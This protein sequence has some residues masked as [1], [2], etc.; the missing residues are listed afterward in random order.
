MAV[1][2]RSATYDATLVYFDEPQVI[3]LISQ[4]TRIVAIA[5]P[6]G[7]PNASMFLAT[8]VADKDWNKY[9]D[10][11]VDLRYL[12][13]YPTVRVQYHFDLQTMKDKK[14]MMTPW[15]GEIAEKY[16]P[17]A[18]FFSTNHTED[19]KADD[20][21]K[22]IEKLLIDGEW[23]LQDFGQFQ[24]KYADVYAFI[25]ATDT[26]KS[27]AASVAAKRKVK[28]AFLDR[29]FRGGFSYVHLFRDLSE[30]VPRS[31]QLNLSKIKYA[32]P[33][34]VEIFG[35]EDVFYHLHNIIPNFLHKREKLSERY[36]VFHKYLSENHYFKID[37]HEYP[38][39]DPT[40]NFMKGRAK[41]LAEEMLAPDFDA[42]WE[43]TDE[44]ALV[45][46]KVVLSFYRR[47]NDAA[48]YFAQGRIAYSD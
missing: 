3:T 36:R 47:L 35:N 18:R 6:Y 37:G 4:K 46:A 24:Q 10:G 8:T 16:L 34:H 41:E 9:L 7:N 29:P 44:N 42:V 2:R 43:L 25:I 32:S 12:F 28:D 19:Y 45:A 1:H 48:T 21:A 15:D 5:I 17:L 30:N 14:V 39:N 38:K 13:T 23:E 33:G 22:D 26:W 11:T 27:A 31:D 20:R 40:E